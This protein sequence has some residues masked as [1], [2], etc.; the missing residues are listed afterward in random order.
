MNM[1]AVSLVALLLSVL[2]SATFDLSIEM[3]DAF[4]LFY[5]LYRCFMNITMDKNEIDM[6]EK[7]MSECK[8]CIPMAFFI[9]TL[10]IYETRT[11]CLSVICMN[12]TL[13]FR[14]KKV[15]SAIIRILP[16]YCAGA[17][18]VRVWS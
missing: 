4:V 12:V 18:F 3:K 9:G 11:L 1:F 6:V 5:S 2:T 16:A 17:M 14:V 10:K 8:M 7:N 13:A 15:P